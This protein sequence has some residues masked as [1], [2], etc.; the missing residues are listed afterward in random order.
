M[1]CPFVIADLVVF[2]DPT[3]AVVKEGQDA[4]L[5]IRTEEPFDFSFSVQLD[6]TSGSATGEPL[7]ISF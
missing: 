5:M 2:F 6:T 3:M 4:I 1:Y 7:P